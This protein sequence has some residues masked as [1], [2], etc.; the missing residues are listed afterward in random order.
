VFKYTLQTTTTRRDDRY[1]FNVVS[2]AR[3]GG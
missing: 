3:S 1:K 2:E